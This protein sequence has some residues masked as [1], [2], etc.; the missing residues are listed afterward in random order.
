LRLGHD[1][2]DRSARRPARRARSEGRSS[3]CPLEG[4]TSRAECR[5]PPV[6]PREA[7]RRD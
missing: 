6:H 5:T 1:A 3:S 7:A 4:C 2:P